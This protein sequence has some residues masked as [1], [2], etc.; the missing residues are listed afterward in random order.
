[1]T[2]GS[3]Q[4]ALTN[5]SLRNAPRF[6]TLLETDEGKKVLRIVL[7]ADTQGSVEAIVNALK[8]I[9]SKK[10]D[11][12]T[13]HSAVGPI[14][15]S[16]ILLA[17]A[18]NAVVVGFNVKVETMAV[19]AA[20]REGVQIKLY[21]IIYELLDQI[22]DAMAGLLDPAQTCSVCVERARVERRCDRDCGLERDGRNVDAQHDL[23]ARDRLAGTAGGDEAGWAPHGVEA[24]NGA[25]GRHEIGGQAGRRPRRGRA[26]RPPSSLHDLPQPIQ[27]VGQLAGGVALPQQALALGPLLG[28]RERL[29]GPGVQRRESA[30]AVEHDEISGPDLGAADHDGHVELA[31]LAFRRALRAHEPRPDRQAELRELVE[32]AHG[33]VDQHRRNTAHLRLGREQLADE[34]D[35][36]GLAARQHEH[37]ARTRVSDHCVHH[38]VVAGRAARGASRPGDTRAR[39]DLRQVE[40]DDPN[41]PRRFMDRGDAERANAA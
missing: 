2:S 14:S 13:I 29:G 15:E 16:D 34:R 39:H 7:K 5:F 27:V 11:L 8:Q 23:R 3:R 36:R 38:R 9:E 37:V 25:A 21:S 19:S 20:K 33:A 17:S 18:S 31:H 12:E 40:V 28:E 22:K 24:P 1:M 4:N 41:A 26:R 30:V 6:E 10:I 32:I 35:R